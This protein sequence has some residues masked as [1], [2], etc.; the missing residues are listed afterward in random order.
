MTDSPWKVDDQSVVELEEAASQISFDDYLMVVEYKFNP[1]DREFFEE[2]KDTYKKH[3]STFND[4]ESKKF[5]AVFEEN[6]PTEKYPFN[7]EM[8]I[9]S[10]DRQYNTPIEIRGLL[11]A[12]FD[13][14]TV[15]D[16]MET[17]LNFFGN[18]ITHMIPLKDIDIEV[19]FNRMMIITGDE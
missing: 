12:S 16:F 8:V 18:T 19:M 1:L 13:D 2:F 5:N 11:I 15:Q 10:V 4:S 17:S 14:S 7:F 6:E 9:T 3:I